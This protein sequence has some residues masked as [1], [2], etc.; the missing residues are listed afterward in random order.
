MR[1]TPALVLCFITVVP[2]SQVS[3]QT[4]EE[5]LVKTTYAKLK[6][7]AQAHGVHDLVN[8]GKRPTL[9]EIE[10][11]LASNDLRF[12]ISNFS[13]GSVKDISQRKF[14][15]LVT[16]P[17][18]QDVVMIVS[19]MNKYTEDSKANLEVSE[20]SDYSANVS[21]SHG[22]NLIGEDWNVPVGD[23]LSSAQTQNR[24]TYSRYASYSV[25]VTFRGRS[26]TYK[27][28]FLFGVG[29]EPVL[30]LDNVTNNSGLSFFEKHSVYPA[31]LLRRASK[32]PGV[33]AWLR[34]RQVRSSTCDSGKQEVCC[35]FQALTCGVSAADIVSALGKGSGVSMRSGEAAPALSGQPNARHLTT[36]SMGAPLRERHMT[37]Y[38]HLDLEH[39]MLTLIHT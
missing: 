23:A 19:T 21:W 7:A 28:M 4:Q 27:A 16:K 1:L 31:V 8:A 20:T 18:G 33:A 17:D 3:G 37:S 26:R 25:S 29:E 15:E 5:K 36:V 14:I 38:V 34:S 22:Q 2:L 10:R 30:V 6:F 32:E 12:E 39:W 24:S 35:D 9:A 11:Y 13:S